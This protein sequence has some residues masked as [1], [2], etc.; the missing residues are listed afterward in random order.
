MRIDL[1]SILVRDQASALS[2]YTNV[3]GFVLTADVPAGEYRWITVASPED[4]RGVQL[5]L[6]PVAFPPAATYQAA[7]Y[8]AG[9]PWTSF[10]VEDV[11]AECARLAGLGVRIVSPPQDA[12]WGPTAVFDDTCGNLI[13]LHQPPAKSV[14]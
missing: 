11:E 8:E 3:L 13:M 9:I 4:P 12:G 6:E 1:C 7:L 14:P 5:V 2:F 10:L